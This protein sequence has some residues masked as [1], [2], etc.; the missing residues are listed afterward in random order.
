[1]TYLLVFVIGAWLSASIHLGLR[2]W[3]RDPK[4]LSRTSQVFVAAMVSLCWPVRVG[5]AIRE[6]VLRI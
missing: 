3:R 5:M 6:W 2:E 1:M 4:V